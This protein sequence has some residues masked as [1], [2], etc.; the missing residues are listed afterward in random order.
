MPSAWFFSEFKSSKLLEN[1][2]F[3]NYIL[4]EA[5]QILKIRGCSQL[6]GY[7]YIIL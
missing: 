4:K 5:L 7:G 3:K 1:K 6:Q 2:V